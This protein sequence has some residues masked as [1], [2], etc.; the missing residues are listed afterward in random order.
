MPLVLIPAGGFTFLSFLAQT[1]LSSSTRSAFFERRS[2]PLYIYFIQQFKVSG[3]IPSTAFLR[4]G[5]SRHLVISSYDKCTHC[6]RILFFFIR[7]WL[8]SAFLSIFY[9]VKSVRKFSCLTVDLVVSVH[10]KIFFPFQLKYCRDICHCQCRNGKVTCRSSRSDKSLRQTHIYN[11][12]SGIP[13]HN[14]YPL[15]CLLNGPVIRQWYRGVAFSLVLHTIR[16]VT[17]VSYRAWS[18][19]YDLALFLSI[20]ARCS[21]F[22]FLLSLLLGKGKG[23]FELLLDKLILVL[24]FSCTFFLFPFLNRYGPLLTFWSLLYGLAGWKINS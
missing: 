6:K 21:V 4:R 22:G 2:G 14:S 17:H 13:E 5:R 15:R 3:Y 11:S 7:K 8:K 19:D 24:Y 9:V 16:T 12:V 18:E 23:S 20:A 1:H 10:V